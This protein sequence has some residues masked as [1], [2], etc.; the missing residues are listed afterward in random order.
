MGDYV[1][2]AKL[3]Y[4]KIPKHID[5]LEKA[6]PV[7]GIVRHAKIC[8]NE[9]M[10]PIS[11]AIDVDEPPNKI[12]PVPGDIGYNR[13][14]QFFCSWYAPMTPLGFTN[15]VATVDKA[16]LPGYEKHMKGIW[17]KPGA[18]IKCEIVEEK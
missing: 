5:A 13:M 6:F 1:V 14:G 3:H 8:D 2:Y 4:D 15:L 9:W 16:D 7:T 17:K 18:Q 10:L 12:K 11:A